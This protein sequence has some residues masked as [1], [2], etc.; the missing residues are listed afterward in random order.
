MD[1]NKKVSENTDCF[2]GNLTHAEALSFDAYA[3]LLFY[4]DT[5]EHAVIKKSMAGDLETEVFAM[6]TGIV[7]GEQIYPTGHTTLLRRWINVI[8]VDS[9]SQQ[10]R[11]PSGTAWNDFFLWKIDTSQI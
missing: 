11:M 4:S 3:E 5:S 6:Q 10:R 1:S 8:A 9:T 2:H 7:R